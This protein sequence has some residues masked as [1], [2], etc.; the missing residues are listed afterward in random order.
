MREQ[1]A[2]QLVA[3]TTR[4]DTGSHNGLDLIQSLVPPHYVC[5]EYVP[6]RLSE[7][8]AYINQLQITLASFI[9]ISRWNQGHRPGGVSIHFE[10]WCRSYVFV[11]PSLAKFFLKGGIL[12][13]KAK[14]NMIV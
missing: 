2:S 14:I 1:T 7:K 6:Q 10:K 8:D 12:S 3:I 9:Q 4:S 5:N 11:P 13:M